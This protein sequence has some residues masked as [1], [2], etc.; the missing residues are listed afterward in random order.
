MVSVADFLERFDALVIL[1]MVAGVFFKVGGFA[2]AAAVGIS[3]L[4]KLKQSRSVFLA[5]GTIITP[6]SLISATSYV[7]H[8]DVGFKLYVPYVHTLLQIIV[9]IL[10]LC[11][12]VIRKKLDPN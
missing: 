6:L 5:L 10:L 4:I 1:M 2:F 9:P 3:Q 11:I 7:E 8:L 12:A